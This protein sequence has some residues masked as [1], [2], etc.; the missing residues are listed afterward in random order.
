MVLKALRARPR[1]LVIA[2]E[3]V[4]RWLLPTLGGC[5]YAWEDGYQ[6]GPSQAEPGLCEYD[7]G[8]IWPY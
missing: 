4:S 6:P 3:L 7:E 2:H 5:I 1:R 8:H